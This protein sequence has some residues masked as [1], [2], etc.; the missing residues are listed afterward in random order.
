MATDSRPFS[1]EK[2]KAL[3]AYFS[4]LRNSA[5]GKPEHGDLNTSVQLCEQ[6]ISYM[7]EKEPESK[8]PA[9]ASGKQ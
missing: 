1:L 2:V 3:K 6:L 9:A 8:K 7:S 4:R 5:R